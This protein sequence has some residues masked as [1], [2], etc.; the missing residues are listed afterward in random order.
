MKKLITILALIF[1]S[2]VFA[3]SIVIFEESSSNTE[4]IYS[5]DF[6]VNKDLNRA[7]VNVSV[8]DSWGD[9]THYSDSRVK[10]K[11]LSYNPE[12]NGVVYDLNGEQVLCGT[13]YN[14]RWVIDMGMSYRPTGRCTFSNK[15]IKAVVDNG[16]EM[17]KVQKLQVT[18]TVE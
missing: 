8:A 1:S 12:L 11:G 18:L 6:D 13:F 4:E 15:R 5:V 3:E 10:V 16:F 17:V 9:S 14:A 2:A 7:W